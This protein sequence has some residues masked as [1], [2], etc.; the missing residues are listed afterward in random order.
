[1]DKDYEQLLLAEPS[2]LLS[3]VSM[4]ALMKSSLSSWSRRIQRLLVGQS[5]S[6]A[7]YWYKAAAE[8]GSDSAKLHYAIALLD[9]VGVAKDT[10]AGLRLMQEL[11]NSGNGEVE[12]IFP[13]IWRSFSWVANKRGLSGAAS[14]K[15]H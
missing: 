3:V 13:E 6:Q 1:M 5:D 8:S 10:D 14:R 15:I 2:A 12:G 11:L 9:G 7:A 4:L